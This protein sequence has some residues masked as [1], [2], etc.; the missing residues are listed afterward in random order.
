[1]LG[2]PAKLRSSSKSDLCERCLQE[3]AESIRASRVAEWQNDVLGA[4]EAVWSERD[5][6]K[7]TS[8][9][10]LWD[11]F[12]LDRDNGGADKRSDRGECLSRLNGSTLAKLRGWLETN[13][14]EAVR[15]Y[16]RYAFI[17]LKADVGLLA[18]LC[19][20]PSDKSLLPD[21]DKQDVTPPFDAVGYKCSGRAIDVT[22]PIQL[23]LLRDERGYKSERDLSKE[24]GV[25]RTTL[26]HIMKRMDELGFSLEKFTTEDLNY[27]T[28]GP[29]HESKDSS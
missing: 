4:I 10:S 5:T 16:G 24:L 28:R 26:R 8:K 25:P 15:R 19:A 29:Q 18:G 14:E 3:H 6:A 20:W 1:M 11:L 2:E 17:G 22:I 12:D 9:A 23:A 13:E 21:D 27:I 7:A